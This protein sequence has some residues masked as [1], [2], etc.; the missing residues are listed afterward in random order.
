MQQAQW[1][2]PDDLTAGLVQ[3][4]VGSAHRAPHPAISRCDRLSASGRAS[5][6]RVITRLGLN[7]AR[8]A[9]PMTPFSARCPASSG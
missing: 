2:R 7:Q 1:Q 9:R 6:R 4:G 5:G 8:P 3:P